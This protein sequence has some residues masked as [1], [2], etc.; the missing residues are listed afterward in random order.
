MTSKYHPEQLSVFSLYCVI[1][2]SRINSNIIVNQFQIFF[3]PSFHYQATISY[4]DNTGHIGSRM[5][6][7][8]LY[9]QHFSLTE[10]TFTLSAAYR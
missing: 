8:V 9:K 3:A 4:L 7:N 6:Q 2:V 5:A 1:I 10:E